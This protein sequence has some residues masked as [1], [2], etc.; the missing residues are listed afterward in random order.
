MII[1][2]GAGLSGLTAGYQLTRGGRQ[3]AVVEKTNAVGGLS[4]TISY[5]GHRFDLGGHRFLTNDTKID[6]LVR[7]LLGEDLLTVGRKS[8]ICFRGR[9][10]DYPLKPANA[11]FGLGIHTTLKILLDY[12]KEKATGTL[13]S[14]KNTSLEDWVVARFGRTM[15]N[16]YFKEYSEKVWG[17]DC[18][19]IDM[20]WIAQRIDGLSLWQALKNAFSK[21]SGK[22]LKI[23]ADTFQYPRWGIGQIS[24][25]LREGIVKQNKVMTGTEVIKIHHCNGQVN[26]V[27]LE[28]A[29]GKERLFGDTFISSIPLTA[30]LN[31]FS[32]KPPENVLEA[33]SKL[34][35]R[36][37]ATVTLLVNR[38]R[39]TDLTWMYLPE[40]K[41]PFGRI[42]EPPNW[43]AT[44]APEGKTHLVAE[45]F[46]KRG[47][48]IWRSTDRHLT[49]LTIDHLEHLGFIDRHEVMGSCVLRIP[50]AY[51]VFE[52][53][54]KE[55]LKRIMDYLNRF[56]NLRVIGRSGMFNYL[57]MDVA[58]ASGLAAAED[59]LSTGDAPTASTF[60]FA[61]SP[62]K[63]QTVSA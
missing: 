36:S 50:H 37:L 19:R 46:C 41:I 63:R 2:L 48:Q 31:R 39:V 28:D 59:I 34:A 16:L 56:Q 55:H 18:N 62:S 15:F 45:F 9:Y 38:E 1:I 3:A 43:S 35:F 29:R 21:V 7:E 22:D 25:R 13:R 14:G 32:P 60:Q 52:V 58:M 20:D 10:V 27:E 57:N 11:V 54:Y 47:D 12:C 49:E 4:R 33:V 44:M 61:D 8:Q 42:H 24:D 53:G 40:K 17:T 23:L 51:P 6:A 26:S 5:K 30:L